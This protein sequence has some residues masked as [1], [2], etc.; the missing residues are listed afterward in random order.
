MNGYYLVQLHGDTWS[1]YLPVFIANG[2]FQ[3]KTEFNRE[4]CVFS[5]YSK[6]PKIEK[7]I[8][9]RKLEYLR[10]L[11]LIKMDYQ[12]KTTRHYEDVFHDYDKDLYKLVLKKR[13]NPYKKEPIEKASALCYILRKIVNT[14]DTKLIHLFEILDKNNKV[15]I[16]YN[17]DYELEILRGIKFVDGRDVAEWN[18]HKHEEIPKTDRWAYLVQ[19][20][21]GAEAWNCI[22]TNVMV[23][24]SQNYSYKIMEQASGRID[25]RNTPF[26]DLYYY[27]LKTRSGIDLSIS[28]ALKDKK[29][30]NESSWIS[31]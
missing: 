11:L 17:F 13:W 3:N 26:K 30:F 27:T 9:T 10:D 14:D 15:I 18:G 1:D 16:F 2:F 25:R 23:F 21:A 12:N 20:S 24:Y 8:G 28:K 22:E 6:F 31:F 4:H 7:Y 29:I 5:R 19:Y